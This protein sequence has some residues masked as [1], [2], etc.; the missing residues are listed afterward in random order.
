MTMQDNNQW[1]IIECEIKINNFA[2]N[3]DKNDDSNEREADR[4]SSSQR[5]KKF[6]N[7]PTHVSLEIEPEPLKK[8]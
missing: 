1:K 2:L 5:K 8:A 7:A 6:N 4:P 3:T